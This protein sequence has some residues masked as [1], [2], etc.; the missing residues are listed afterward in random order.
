[1][2]EKSSWYYDS[3]LMIFHKVHFGE[4]SLE[5]IFSSW[6]K[7]IEGQELPAN[8][9]KFLIDFSKAS[10]SFPASKAVEI[11]NFYKKHDD[12]FGDAKIAMLMVEPNQV[13]L[14]IMV[15]L[16]GVGFDIKPFS[17][18]QGAISWLK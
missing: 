10:I 4:I 16:Q 11:A 8:S 5:E 3:D 14:P 18:M 12:V 15:K 17:T 9:K 6:T 13:V 7:I 2:Q 1:M